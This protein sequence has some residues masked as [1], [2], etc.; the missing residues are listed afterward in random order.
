MATALQGKLIATTIDGQFPEC[1]S[2]ATMTF[3]VNTEE[4]DPCKPAPGQSSNSADWA[5]P[6]VSSKTGTIDFSAKAF[7]DDAVFNQNDIADLIIDGDAKVQWQFS[8]TQTDDYGHPVV[9]VYS[10]EGIITSLTVNAEV[11]GEG[12]YDTS[13]IM[14]GKPT[15]TVTPITT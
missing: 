14:Y 5:L 9:W 13:I 6:T 7:A 1:Q 2:S 3:T 8:T 11:A 15:K 12:T 4:A 10:G